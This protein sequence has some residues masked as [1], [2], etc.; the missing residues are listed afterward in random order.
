M[1]SEE[2]RKFDTDEP[3]LREKLRAVEEELI[4]FAAP[5]ADQTRDRVREAVGRGDVEAVRHEG[6]AWSGSVGLSILDLSDELESHC[7]QTN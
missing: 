4:A 2:I 1:K 6:N 5:L 3:S 7:R